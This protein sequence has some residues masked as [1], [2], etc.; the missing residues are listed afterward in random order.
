MDR[1]RK[2]YRVLPL[3]ALLLGAD[4]CSD[5][6]T[7]SGRVSVRASGEGAALNGYPYV[8]NGATIAFADGWA[9][10]FSKYIASVG[11]LRLGT[12]DGRTAFDSSDVFVLDLHAGP[13]EL[14]S[15]PAIEARRW[16]RFGFD[17]EAP[18]A[19]AKTVGDVSPA[20]VDAMR[21]AG[22][23]YLVEGTAEKSGRTVRF[24]WGISNPVRA[25]N[26]TNGID[27][28]EG[29]VVRTNATADVEITFHLDHLFWD[30]L[31]TEVAK[32]RFD[33]VAAAAGSDG[34]VT[35]DELAT[36]PLA[37]LI[38]L[39]GGPLLDAD[40]SRVVYN[41]GSVPLASQTLQAF[42]RATSAGQAHL[43]GTGLCTISRR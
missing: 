41:P 21:A 11:H 36:Q 15:F 20:D 43:N 7:A 17:V 25:T 42:M 34:L 24:S 10:R 12:E 19:T 27:G 13:A 16:E 37:D 29:V 23:N 26:C 30:T 4:A 9:L 28:T 18:S 1:R 32:L 39:D 2:K 6:G 31:G 8:K 5:A 38:G 35:W 40:G 3:V 14:T 33:A 22:W